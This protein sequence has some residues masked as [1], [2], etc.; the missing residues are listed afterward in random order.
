M[1]KAKAELGDSVSWPITLDYVVYAASTNNTNVGLALEKS[2]EDAIG[3]YVQVNLVYAQTVDDYY[4]AYYDIETGEQNSIDFSFGAGWGPDYGDP[5]TYLH[6]Y[7]ANDGDML[8]YSGLNL[9]SETETESQLNAKKV[10]GLYD[11][12]EQIALAD[13]LVGD[14]RIDAFAKAEAMLLT[15]GIYRPYSTSGANLVISKVKPFSAAY[16]LYGQASY[17]AVPYFKYME[18]LDEPVTAADYYAAK[19][20]WLAGK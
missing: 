15:S 16:G 4:A 2:I 10:T 5:L 9:A 19:E 13:S 17:N 11:I 7:E 20:A 14:E 18:L 8:A 12:A 1:E 3:E 6:C